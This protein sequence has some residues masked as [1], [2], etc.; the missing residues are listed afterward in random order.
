MEASMETM[1]GQVAHAR[2][3]GVISRSI[4]GE[5]ILVPARRRASEMALFTLNEVGSFVWER[6][7]GQIGPLRRHQSNRSSHGRLLVTRFQS[8][9]FG[10]NVPRDSPQPWSPT[11]RLQEC[12]SP[13][14]EDSGRAALAEKGGGP[15]AWQKSTCGVQASFSAREG[16]S[17]PLDL[18][19]G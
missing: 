11:G 18:C 9:P 10:M 15:D 6:L 3:P 16:L 17:G 7:D 12:R 2:Q 1:E 19:R 4:A 14:K 5:T 8:L 13:V